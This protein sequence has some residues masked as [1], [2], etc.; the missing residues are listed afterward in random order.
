MEVRRVRDAGAKSWILVLTGA[1]LVNSVIRILYPQT[2]PA[3]KL[4]LGI[5]GL[6]PFAYTLAPSFDRKSSDK[7]VK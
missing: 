4:L 6:F 1:G 3:A 7:L 2:Y 5:I